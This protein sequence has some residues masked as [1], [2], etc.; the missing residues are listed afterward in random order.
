MKAGC[1]GCRLGVWAPFPGAGVWGHASSSHAL[2][3]LGRWGVWET[4]RHIVLVRAAW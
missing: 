1:P 4:R 2:C 3:L